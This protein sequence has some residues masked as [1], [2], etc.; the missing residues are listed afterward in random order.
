MPPKY[1]TKSSGK[2]V[3]GEVELHEIKRFDN[4][5]NLL[6]LQNQVVGHFLAMQRENFGKVE[7]KTIVHWLA[8]EICDIWTKANIPCYTIKAIKNKVE[9]LVNRFLKLRQNKNQLS[10][11]IF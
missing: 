5:T 9:S 7:R 4:K 2:H 11:P 3:I 6:P 10:K 1:E 8:T